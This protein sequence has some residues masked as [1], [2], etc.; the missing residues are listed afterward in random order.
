L[1]ILNT[2]IAGGS[3][4]KVPAN[5]YEIMSSKLSTIKKGTN[6]IKNK[7]VGKMV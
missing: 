5:K 6:V 2:K 7:S 4:D 1:K 3:S